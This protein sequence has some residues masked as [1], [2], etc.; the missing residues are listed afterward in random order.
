YKD[1]LLAIIFNFFLHIRVI[2]YST[3]GVLGGFTRDI[4]QNKEFFKPTEDLYVFRIIFLFGLLGA[5]ITLI[6]DII[7]NLIGLLVGFPINILT[8]VFA[9][10][11]ILGNTLVFVFLLPGLIQLV[12]KLLD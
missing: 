5:I 9:A 6:F 12:M 4:L 8:V 11:H 10:V 7:T 2:H 1:I 3:T